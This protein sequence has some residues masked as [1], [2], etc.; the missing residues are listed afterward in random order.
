MANT[1]TKDIAKAQTQYWS[2]EQIAAIAG[3][4][5]DGAGGATEGLSDLEASTYLR[6]TAAA[7]TVTRRVISRTALFTMLNEPDAG[8]NPQ[9]PPILQM[10][11]EYRQAVAK[12]IG[13]GDANVANGLLVAWE[14]NWILERIADGI[15]QSFIDNDP[16]T[17]TKSAVFWMIDQMKT[18]GWISNQHVQKFVDEAGADVTQ[19]IA[20]SV[21]V[22]NVDG[23]CVG[24]ARGKTAADLG[25]GLPAE[26]GSPAREHSFVSNGSK[27]IVVRLSLPNDV[28]AELGELLVYAWVDNGPAKTLRPL[29]GAG[30]YE[31]SIRSEAAAPGK[32]QVLRWKGWRDGM[33][34]LTGIVVS[35]IQ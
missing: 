19:T 18:Q 32:T 34:G 14:A 15:E 3:V 12:V 29:Q 30:E 4:L 23:R 5:D 33:P 8:A 7:G 6:T 20:D 17:G 9:V 26:Y 31:F 24:F 25:D 21:G 2:D 10:R 28:A 11:D 27:T 35:G 22:P 13:L 1:Y 16:N